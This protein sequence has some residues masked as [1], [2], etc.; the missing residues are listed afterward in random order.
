V[1]KVNGYFYRVLVDRDQATFGS[2]VL[3]AAA[4]FI[5]ATLLRSTRTFLTGYFSLM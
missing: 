5:A 4:A 3:G 1:G 2:V